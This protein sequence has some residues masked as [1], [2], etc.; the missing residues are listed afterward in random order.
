MRYANDLFNPIKE[1]FL[2]LKKNYQGVK[3]KKLRNLKKFER[4]TNE[5]LCEAYI[6]M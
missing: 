4:K 6:R 5:N 2:K 3:M 1:F